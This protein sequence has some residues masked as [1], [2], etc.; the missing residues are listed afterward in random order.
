MQIL[1][2]IFFFLSV[3]LLPLPHEKFPITILSLPFVLNVKFL[4]PNDTFLNPSILLYNDSFP[5]LILSLPFVL[6]YKDSNPKDI[7]LLLTLLYNEL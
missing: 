6:L 4:L 5:I 1:L 3:N 7:L 2:Y